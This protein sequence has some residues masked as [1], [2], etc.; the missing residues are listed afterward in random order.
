MQCIQSSASHPERGSLRKPDL[1]TTTEGTSGGGSRGVGRLQAE[2]GHDERRYG[3]HGGDAVKAAGVAAESVFEPAGEERTEESAEIAEGVD[4]GNTCRRTGSGEKRTGHGP[5]RRLSS[6]DTDVDDRK[7][8][9]EGAGGLRDASPYE[10]KAWGDAGQD[11]VPSAFNCPV[12]MASPGDHGRDGD[13]GRCGVE[14]TDGER[15]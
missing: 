2:Q 8:Q 1:L 11:H 3:Q 10:T 4:H 5:Q 12:R 9:D 6:I 13:Q 14:Q 7:R 15:G